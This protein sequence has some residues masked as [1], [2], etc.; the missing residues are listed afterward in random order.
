MAKELEINDD[1]LWGR[2]D[3]VEKIADGIYEVE[4]PSHGGIM[5]DPHCDFVKYDMSDPAWNIPEMDHGWFCF[6]E[7]T[8][9]AVIMWELI[10]SDTDV[11]WYHERYEA[12]PDGYEE[13]LRKTI[14]VF[15]PLYA[16]AMG[17]E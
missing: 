13:M 10:H 17:I 6:E 15:Y 1:T 14:V 2:A 4:T 5:A 8:A 16:E 7:D 12:D 9:F 3:Y 11:E